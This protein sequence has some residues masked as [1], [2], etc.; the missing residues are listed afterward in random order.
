MAA[1][2][3]DK[4][5]EKEFAGLDLGDKRLNKRAVKLAEQLAGKPTSSIPVATGGWAEAVA[6][7]R[8]LSNEK[9][10]WRDILAPHV[11][12]TRRRMSEHPVVLCLQRINGVG[13]DWFDAVRSF[14]LFN[15]AKIFP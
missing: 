1:I 6:A 15:S 10:E 11:E 2:N 5:G 14:L 3:K 9:V 4:W 13:L 7:Y 12:Q 8:F